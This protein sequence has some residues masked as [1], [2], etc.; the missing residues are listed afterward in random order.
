MK[1]VKYVGWCEKHQKRLFTKKD[2]QRAKRQIRDPGLRKYKCTDT[3]WH[4]GHLAPEIKN[5]TKTAKQVYTNYHEDRTRDH[6][7]R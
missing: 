2:A 1:Y 3:L 6:N 7:Q 4:I 5:G